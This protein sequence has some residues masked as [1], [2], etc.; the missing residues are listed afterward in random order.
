MQ[1]LVQACGRYRVNPLVQTAV[2]VVH[3]FGSC[4]PASY[5]H[6][7]DHRRPGGLGAINLGLAW[8]REQG[9]KR[10]QG[11]FDRNT[12][13]LRRAALASVGV[14]ALSAG[15]A[16]A[17]STSSFRATGAY[18]GHTTSV[19]AC[20]FQPPAA[21]TVD[22]TFGGGRHLIIGLPAYR[23][24]SKIHPAKTRSRYAVD[25]LVGKKLWVAGPG[26]NGPLGSGTFSLSNNDLA[27]QLDAIMRGLNN[28][29]KPINSTVHVV[30]HWHCPAGTTP[31]R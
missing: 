4:G 1:N 10:M 16:G 26:N 18:R 6:T 27:G 22:V 17:A 5:A 12:H 13:A 25:L 3:D 15:V 24:V 8:V 31:H 21:P 9:A 19:R 14:V 28:A 20:S 2:A 29:G 30:A 7:I 23:N 11:A